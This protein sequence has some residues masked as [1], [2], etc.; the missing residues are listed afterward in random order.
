MGKEAVEELRDTVRLRVFEAIEPP[1]QKACKSFVEEGSHVGRGVKERILTLFEDLASSATD[2]ASRP[3]ERTL[4][5][6]YE[7]VNADV[8]KALQEW[9]N[10][11][12]S[13]ADAI[14]ARHESRIERSDAQRRNR[15]L[16]ALEQVRSDAPEYLRESNREVAAGG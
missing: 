16:A 8:G 4:L 11:L 1:I 15:I 6:N 2:A 14:V 13:T 9:G 12:E 7:S 5:A 3:T 10:P